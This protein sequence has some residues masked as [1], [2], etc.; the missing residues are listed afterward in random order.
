MP[1]Q[2]FHIFS[3]NHSFIAPFADF[4]LEK[5]N[6]PKTLVIFPHSRPAKYLQRE[7]AKRISPNS[8]QADNCNNP[9][10]HLNLEHSGQKALIMPTCLTIQELFT[11]LSSEL[12]PQHILPNA[13]TTTALTG[14]KQ[15]QL[16]DQV[17]LLYQA[18]KA[19]MQKHEEHFILNF[20]LHTPERFLPWG[21]RLAGLMEDFFNTRL[22]PANY[23]HLQGM[24]TDFA[25]LLLSN[26]SHIHKAYLE[27][28]QANNMT[29]P[30]LTA[31]KLA[32][33]ALQGLGNAQ[34][35]FRFFQDKNIIIAGFNLLS[36]TEEPVLRYLWEQENAEICLHTDPKIVENPQKS[37][38]S[39]RAHFDWLKKWRASAQLYA[40][41]Y[42]AEP[43]Q[44]NLQSQTDKQKDKQNKLVIYE[45]YDLHSQLHQ[46]NNELS[47][48]KCEEDAAIILPS[49][50][51]LLPTLHS[52]PSKNVNISM[53]YP[54][55]RSPLAQMLRSVMELQSSGQSSEQNFGQNFGQKSI[56]HSEQNSLPCYFE[57]NN[58]NTDAPLFNKQLN[59]TENAHA[60][61]Y[62]WK[63]L[64]NLL[65]HPYLRMLGDEENLP[66]REIL[67]HIEA[68]ILQGGRFVSLAEI[69][70]I[71]S[72][73]VSSTQPFEIQSL[74]P[75]LEHLPEHEKISK[76]DPELIEKTHILLDNALDLLIL[77][78]Q[79]IKNIND[80]TALLMDLSRFLLAKG[81]S[82][83]QRFPLDGEYLYRLM[84]SVIPAL[85][86]SLFAKEELSRETLFALL[87]TSLE[88][89]RVPFEAY[90]LEGIQ[91]LGMLESRLLSFRNLYILDATEDILPG[92]PSHDPLLPDPLRQEIGL[93]GLYERERIMAH[94]F[95]RLKHSASNVFLFY[96]AGTASTGI[97]DEKKTRSRFIE[98][99]LWEEEKA[100][101]QIIR[102]NQPPLHAISFELHSHKQ[103]LKQIIR[104]KPINDAVNRW[105]AKGI[106]P[107]SLDVY[108]SCPLRF[109][110]EKI[111]RL[112]P[113]D[114]LPEGNDPQAVGSL[115]H[116]V[117]EQFFQ[118][119][120]GKK[121]QAGFPDQ[122][123]RQELLTQ[124]RQALDASDLPESQP[125]DSL[126]ML[127]QT[128]PFRLEKFL[129]NIPNTE[130]VALEQPFKAELNV[131]NR[132]YTLQGRIDRIDRRQEG[133]IIIDYKTGRPPKCN[134][135]FWL[136]SNPLW[137]RMQQWKANEDSCLLAECCEEL[138]SLQLPVYLYAY[139]NNLA[140]QASDAA[141]VHLADQGQEIFLLKNNVPPD[142][143][144]SVLTS[145]IPTLLRFIIKHLHESETFSPQ[146]GNHCTY[147]PWASVC[148]N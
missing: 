8:K 146:P 42:D 103:N 34:P 117:L 26:L 65:R 56:Q 144:N 95:Y 90:P 143:Y 126:L 57:N 81:A 70:A 46:L 138:Q 85:A 69:K 107:S 41:P 27:L 5:G 59:C 116:K 132:Q 43:H 127:E 102:H 111:A 66:V 30:G 68:K 113:R 75:E 77:R 9:N 97:L 16:L 55:D 83:W 49:A 80:L 88:S 79:D 147:C 121:I 148:K 11:Q 58:D 51:L 73:V 141:F 71:L 109:F 39:C 13:A 86:H 52:L 23:Q 61:K 128:G 24:V 115:I 18:V 82:L 36:G 124:F 31:F 137:L 134:K 101:Q 14:V 84:H 93:P 118:P 21:V 25:A 22:I 4:I 45:G 104:T 48:L 40:C 98:E 139:S 28:L 108:F 106:S 38:W 12:P 114:E 17:A 100:K 76:V 96:Q 136:P 29:T 142:V 123:A 74:L 44:Q 133:L 53:G 10:L 3:W 47:Q 6:L 120:V 37:H 94:T 119:Y 2:P 7:L 89:E 50:G 60:Y 87:N 54:L 64:L 125:L 32:D 20:P 99:L 105:L 67:A 135:D 129:N 19:V 140:Y 62:H 122:L 78:W 92:T 33:H 131:E 130:I 72:Q 1:L 91:I 110:Y 15:A 112:T 145:R 35:A 63:A